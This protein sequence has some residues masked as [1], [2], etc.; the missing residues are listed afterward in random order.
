MVGTA[1]GTLLVM[2]NRTEDF[3]RMPVSQ[4]PPKLVSNPQTNI[5]LWLHLKHLYSGLTEDSEIVSLDRDYH[6][7]R[8]TRPASTMIAPIPA[9][10]S[11]RSWYRHLFPYYPGE[12]EGFDQ[13]WHY[14]LRVWRQLFLIPWMLR[15]WLSGQMHKESKDYFEEIN[16]MEEAYR[17]HQVETIRMETIAWGNVAGQQGRISAGYADFS[18][19]LYVHTGSQQREVNR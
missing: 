8:V 5:R 19:T 18:D 4:I 3:G 1:R 7:I 10:I 15:Y 16:R 6:E 9:P 13:N 17:K 14:G 2:N 12:P 11:W